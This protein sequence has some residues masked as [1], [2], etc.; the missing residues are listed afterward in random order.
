MLEEGTPFCPHCGAPQIRVNVPA[1]PP[2]DSS[3]ATLPKDSPAFVPGTPAEMQPPAEPLRFSAIPS[4]AQRRVFS[5]REALPTALAVGVAVGIGALIPL[6]FAWIVLVIGT[7]GA[8]SVVF[9]KRRHPEAFNLR[10]SD[11]VKLGA[12]SSLV[13]YALFAVMTVFAFV[14]NGS[15]L[16]Q[17]IIKRM[18]EMKNPDPAMQQTYQQIMEKLATPEGM[19][20]M[21]TL[22]LA[23]LFVFFLVLGAAG[24]AIGATLTHREHH[25]SR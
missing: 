8:L 17:E 20:L 5:A 12:L 25:S 9:Y 21:I 13:G 16:R 3:S 14:V 22:A 1:E 15:A 6:G 18:Q 4:A 2:A 11:G 24:G 19:A 23:F 10:A 7:G